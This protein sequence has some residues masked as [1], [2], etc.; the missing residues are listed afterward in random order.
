MKKH[1][2]FLCLI[3][4]FGCADNSNAP[5]V[6]QLLPAESTGISFQNEV[7]SSKDFNIL[8]Y[9]YFYNGG[10]VSA[11]DINND[12]LIDLY[13]TA[14]QKPN[15][16]YLNK[17]NLTFEDIT[18]QAGV[19][20]N[21]TWSTGVT[22]AD[23]NG[24]GYLDIYVSQVGDYKLAQ[25]KNELFI[26]NHDGT[27][28]ESAEAYGLDFV[29]FSTQATFFD[30]D[31]DGDLDMYL[32]NHSI[33]NPEVF[34][35]ANSRNKP[36]EQGDKLFENQANSGTQ[37]FIDVTEKAGI[38][39]SI[40]GFGLGVAISDINNDAW[41]DIYVSNDFTENDYLY[42]N[43]Q[44]GTFTEE[45][46]RRI[47][48]TSRFS[49]GNEIADLNNDGLG[50]IITTDML[51][52]DPTIWKKSVV[53]DKS[54]VYKIKL[55]FGYG[56][57]YVRNT[58]QH[59]LGNGQF[60]D[61]SLFTNSFASDW[62]W[63]P[64]IFDMDNDG[65]QDIHITN[66]IYKR[67]ND[68]DYLNYQS[69][70]NEIRQK[71][72]DELEEFL[73]ETLPTLKISNYTGQNHG[74]FNI[75]NKAAD[76]GLDQPSYSNGSTYADLD[77]DGD[78]E[79][80]VNNVR[81]EAFIYENLTNA[82]SNHLKI[83]FNG[84]KQNP[85]GIGTKVSVTIGAQIL[86][87]ENFNTRGF[88]SSIAPE[89]HFGLGKN[90]TID[91]IEVRWPDGKREVLTNQQVNETLTVDYKNAA[92]PNESSAAANFQ[93][94]ESQPLP[95][96]FTHKEDDFNDFDREYLMPRNYNHE[97]PAVAVADVNND[98]L[99]DVYFGGAKEQAGELWLQSENG[100][101]LSKD[102]PV[103]NQLARAEDIAA[104]FFDADNDGDQDLYISTGGNEFPE[105]QL[106][107]YDRLYLN[108]G[109]GNFRFSPRALP[110][111]GAQGKTLAIQDIDQDGDLDVFVGSNIVSGAYGVNPKQYLLIND[112]KGRFQDQINQRIPNANTMGMLNAASWIDY[113]SD[114]DQDLIVAGEWTAIQLYQ[115]DGKGTFQ[116]VENEGLK[117]NKGWW[118]SLKIADLNQ[119]GKPDI[120]VG[121]LG[122]NTKLKAT[123]KEPVRLYLN[124]FDDNGQTDPFVFHYQNGIESPYATRDDLVKQMAA[125]KKLH[126]DYE[127]YS[128]LN[129]PEELFGEKLNE[130][131]L[132]KEASTFQSKVLIN[133]GNGNFEE[134]AL[135][136]EAQ[137]S[138][139]M[140][141]VVDDLDGDGTMD[142]ILYGNNYTYR[143]DYGRADAKPITL[144]L[145]DGKGEFKAKKDSH[146]NAMENWGEFRSARK[147][148]INGQQNY[149]G[150]RNNNSP[151]LF[152]KQ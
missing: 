2:I 120:V 119:D 48:H 148:T 18:D 71:S 55:G 16:L 70:A 138:P 130:N 8:E 25:G 50:E 7:T 103:F 69:S 26:N 151:V 57:Q 19:A 77:N 124:D 79:L 81:Q 29:G 11:G 122:T 127:D 28:T 126:A 17:G 67:P 52:A 89:L 84:P 121:N 108:D 72:Q 145:G 85:F 61:L 86:S 4:T 93:L 5:A 12:G 45:L 42:I 150:L 54:E 36:S 96:T 105:G 34:T 60:S 149:L 66:G 137:Y 99:D 113:D 80:I 102:S 58:L 1:L 30:Y 21:G 92:I 83:R 73:I 76:W 47:Q 88:Q 152:K 14:N 111:I 123:A 3:L 139:V 53:E 140:S 75:E 20:G 68:L 136:Q 37:K 132:I 6:F 141:I 31:L 51:P 27:F 125:I 23:V 134:F 65:Y 78:L 133:K 128:Q 63:S 142:L 22:M 33:K 56:H 143:N 49:M 43:N 40:I 87:R 94:L 110:Q 104:E 97:G 24:D 112:G 107:S 109:Q 64:L 41:P 90:T 9:L 13:F 146:L 144:L 10:G 101:F 106:F 100:T 135:P 82:T 131:T 118:Y 98:G 62:S 15:K 39:S 115:N 114:G 91:R 32:L 38:Y 35:E 59:N 95:F 117:N 74:N 147:I 46:E 116:P 129:G 44:N